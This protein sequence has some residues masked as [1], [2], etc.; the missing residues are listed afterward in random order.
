MR[1]A[2]MVALVRTLW[3][4]ACGGDE[5]TLVSDRPTNEQALRLIRS[6]EV[7]SIVFIHGGEVH[8]TLRGGTMVFVARPDTTALA[9]VAEDVSGD[10]EIAIGLE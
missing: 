5:R 10:C 3:A 6:C 7:K 8:L 4:G 2:A 1:I 9:N